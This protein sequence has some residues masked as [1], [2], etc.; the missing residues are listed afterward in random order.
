MKI[1]FFFPLFVSIMNKPFC[2]LIMFIYYK[3]NENG[4]GGIRTCY[5]AFY[6][7]EHGS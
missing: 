3:H 5:I 4:T 2:F 1:A 6:D 7:D